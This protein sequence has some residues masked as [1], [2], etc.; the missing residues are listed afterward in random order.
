[1]PLNIGGGKVAANKDTTRDLKSVEPKTAEK[2]T[3]PVE[4]KAE[5]KPPEK[6]TQKDS[7]AAPDS[8]SRSKDSQD[9]QAEPK[10]CAPTSRELAQDGHAKDQSSNA[11]ETVLHLEAEA[12]VKA[13]EHKPPHL[14]PPPYVHHFDTYSLVKDLEKGGFT[15]DQSIT[16]M[17][18]VRGLLAVNLD[19][20]KEGLVSKSDVENVRPSSLSTH[21]TP[22]KLT[23][24]Q[25]GNIPL[26][27]R[28]FRTPHRDPKH[29]PHHHRYP[30]HR[31]HPPTTRSRHPQP[32]IDAG[33]PHP[34]GRS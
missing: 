30:P 17:K 29:P 14:Q 28:L 25:P 15:Q 5:P 8:R 3:G 32:E 23:Q 6:E 20:A 4:P 26:P 34:Q 12:S 10:T 13:D 31:T 2:R 11:L 1:M 9:R 24:R 22:L 27:R 16:L 7:N 18:A 21:S 33:P 19:V